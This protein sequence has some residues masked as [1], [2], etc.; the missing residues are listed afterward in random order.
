MGEG[1]GG[2]LNPLIEVTVNSK[3]ESLKTFVP[4]TSKNPA[5][6]LLI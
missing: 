5:L 2:W 1:E 3:E 6:V 4:I